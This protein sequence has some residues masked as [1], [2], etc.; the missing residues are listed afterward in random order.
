MNVTIKVIGLNLTSKN[1]PTCCDQLK[2]NQRMKKTVQKSAN[3]L[4]RPSF[5]ELLSAPSVG[6]TLDIN[7]LYAI[8]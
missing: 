5:F 1:A 7:L 6:Y 4:E 3:L 8:R 2:I